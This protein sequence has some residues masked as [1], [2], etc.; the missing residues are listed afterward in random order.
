MTDQNSTLH[1][2]SATARTFHWITVAAVVVMVPLGFTMAYRGNVLNIWDDT[3]NNLYSAHKLIGFTLLWVLLARLIYRL[4]RGAPPPEPTLESW[5]V[6]GSHVVHWL[7]YAI[8]I[9]MPILGWLG[10]SYYPALDIFGLFSLPALVQPNEEA[11]ARVLSIHATLAFVLVALVAA[12]A[13]MAL[14]HHFIR[15]DNVLRR[16][17]GGR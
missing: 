5:Q 7:L 12:H 3:T 14:Y 8:V 11:A 2:Y 13:T 16:M 1:R 9:A 10:V 15:K 6:A 17:L 4:V